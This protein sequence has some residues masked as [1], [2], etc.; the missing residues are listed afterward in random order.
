MSSKI[1][2]ANSI[3]GLIR[4][5]FSFLDGPLFKKLYTTFVR[6]HLEYGQAVWSPHLKKHIKA[7]E[8]VQRRATKLIDGFSRLSYEERLHRLDLPT[9]AFRRARGDMI[10]LY[11]N[12]YVY[13]KSSLCEAFRPKT[14]R[15][16]GNNLTLQPNFPIDG[17]R[18]VQYNSFLLSNISCME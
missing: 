3:I 14:E 2:K 7:L 10:E 8:K 18:G 11:K 12:F 5:S 4:R 6:P 1:R 9:L 16:R 15:C 13:D 17:V